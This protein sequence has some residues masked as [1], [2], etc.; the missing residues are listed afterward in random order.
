MIYV[1]GD[2]LGIKSKCIKATWQSGA[3]NGAAPARVAL[4]FEQPNMLPNHIE[5]LC[6]ELS[7]CRWIVLWQVVWLNINPIS[8]P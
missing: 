8:N 5:Q 1:F 6:Q 2:M 4:Q 7:T 3:P